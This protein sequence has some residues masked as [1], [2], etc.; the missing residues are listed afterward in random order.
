MLGI[1]AYPYPP[2]RAPATPDL[3]AHR[4]YL[5]HL[6][7]W[8]RCADGFARA[9]LDLPHE[10]E[11]VACEAPDDEEPFDPTAIDREPGAAMRNVL[12]A[13]PSESH[14]ELL[15]CFCM[16]KAAAAF[17]RCGSM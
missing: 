9:L 2:P 7:L 10:T 4:R 3:C 1:Y 16:H 8:R 11:S 17:C 6:E 14:R 13:T 12:C 15:K 5:E